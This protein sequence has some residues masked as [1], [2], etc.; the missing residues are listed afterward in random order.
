MVL[1]L[2]SI[3]ADLE[4][5]ASLEPAE[6]FDYFFEVKCTSCNEKHPKVV[7]LN[8]TEE[9]EVSGGKGNTAHF[10]W[11]CGL[12]KRESSAKFDP[13]KTIPYTEEHS[14]QLA[15]FLK[16]ECR[17]LEF[18]GFEPRG[19]WICRGKTGTV[20]QDVDLV[21]NDMWTDYDEKT[22]EP[23]GVSEFSSEWRRA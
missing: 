10:V 22:S 9:Y 4:N 13:S 7:A 17:G 3:K 18:I 14:G 1:L 2:L 12:C 19:S 16:V 21:E 23:V 15:P 8:R 6:P 11:R 20:F 5:I